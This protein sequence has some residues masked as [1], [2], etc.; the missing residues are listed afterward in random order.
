MAA[1]RRRHGES[2]AAQAKARHGGISVMAAK[3]KSFSSG[4]S[5]MASM[6]AWRRN[7]GEINN[8]QRRNENQ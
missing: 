6:A 3:R 8:K 7:N 4:S 1:A 2:S 5:I